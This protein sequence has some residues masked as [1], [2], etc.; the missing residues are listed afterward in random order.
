MRQVIETGYVRLASA[1]EV[2][3]CRVKDHCKPSVFG[4]GYLGVGPYKANSRRVKSKAYNAWHNM[5]QRCYSE[6]YQEKY[7]YWKD[8]TVVDDWLNFQNFAGW[9]YLNYIE[10]FDLDKD[11]Q[12]KGNRVYGPQACKFI[13]KSE[14]RLARGKP[15]G[16]YQKRT[17][18]KRGN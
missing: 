5:I 1:G 10:G 17:Q 7:P 18:S 2:R 16:Q 4:V 14:N 15:T 6:K 13:P 8:C 11:M 12:I 3:R 9:F